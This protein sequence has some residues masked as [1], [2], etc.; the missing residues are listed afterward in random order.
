MAGY[1]GRG[2]PVAT[3]A[4]P[5]LESLGITEWKNT[6]LGVTP[7]PTLT[8]D[9]GS[10]ELLNYTFTVSNHSTYDIPVYFC[11]VYNGSTLVV[12]NENITDNGDG[13]LTFV[14]PGEGTVEIRVECIDFSNLIKSEIGTMS[15]IVEPQA[16]A[17]HYRLLFDDALAS[18]TLIVAFELYTGQAQTGVLYPTAAMTSNTLPTPYIAYTDWAY[19]DLYAPWKA[20]DRAAGMYWNLAGTP[21]VNYLAIDLGAQ[22][23]INSFSITTGGNFAQGNTHIQSSVDGLWAGEEVTLHTIQLYP[24]T[25]FNVG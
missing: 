23:A 14:S 7:T 20:F 9:P 1:V 5:S 3:I 15:L 18:G 13:T 6:T 21:Y 2:Q 4:L 12:T 8:G 11:E 17:R 25:T 22:L 16:A 24:A 19:S 10:S